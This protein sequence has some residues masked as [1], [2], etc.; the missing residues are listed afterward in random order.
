MS[1]RKEK[2]ARL[3]LAVLDHTLK[4]IGRRPF[5]DLYVEDICQR[6]KIS[7]V[8]L[9]KYFPVKEDILAYY[10]RVWCLRRTVE[11]REKPKEGVQ[12]VVYLFDKLS[13]DFDQHPGIMLS[14]VGYLSNPKRP[15]KPFPLKAEEKKLLFPDV[16]DIHNVEIM[17]I[18]QLMEKFALEGV[19]KKEFT[20]TSNTREITQLL[21]TLFFGSLVTLQ[22][23]QVSPTKPMLRRMVELA[24]KGM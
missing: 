1:L 20:K 22:L 16:A 7:K 18:E 21:M 8:T 24:V 3:K 9:F 15:P 5:E 19:F 23:T 14:V 12:G 2:A 11:L 17:S 4:L 10:F 13:E 6:V